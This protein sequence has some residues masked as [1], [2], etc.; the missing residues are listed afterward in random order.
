MV[1][2]SDCG[3]DFA[4][5]HAVKVHASR[6]LKRG[7]GLATSVKKRQDGAQGRVAAKLACIDGGQDIVAEREEL[8]SLLNEVRKYVRF[9]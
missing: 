3:R 9:H 4:T 8:R 6:C 2:C 5:Q 7:T 1:R